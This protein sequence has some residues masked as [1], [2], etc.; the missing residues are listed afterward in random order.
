MLC[1]SGDGQGSH[2]HRLF[3]NARL[4]L[5]IQARDEI[6]ILRAERLQLLLQALHAADRVVNLFLCDPKGSA[7]SGNRYYRGCPWM[8]LAVRR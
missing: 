4:L 1:F 3:T 6:A 2:V 5:G 7:E 8:G